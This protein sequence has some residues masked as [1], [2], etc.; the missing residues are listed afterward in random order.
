MI[1]VKRVS[2]PIILALL[3]VLLVWPDM[4]MAQM[5]EN[6]DLSTNKRQFRAVWIPTVLNI[7]WPSQPGLPEDQQKEEFTR[8]LDRSKEMG[9][10]AVIVQVRPTADAFYVSKMN[11]WSKYLMGKQ[12]VDPGYDPLSFMVEEAHKRNME[13]HAWFNPYRV[14]MD[15]DRSQLVPEHPARLYPDWVVEYG[16]RLYYN[17]GLPGPREHIVESIREVVRNYDIDAVHFDDYFYPYPSGGVDFP[18]QQTYEEYGKD[19][20][21]NKA[22]WRR[23]NVNQLV[24]QVSQ[25]IKEEKPYVKFGI[26]PFGIWRNKSTDPSGSDTDGLQSYDA[27]YADT[28]AWIQNEWIDYVTP[29]IYWSFGFPPA[30]Y[31]KLV[32]WW[33]N[34]VKDRNVHLYIGHAVYKIAANTPE[35]DN[36]DEIPNQINFNQ[37]FPEVKGSVFFSISDLLRNPLGIA[38]RLQNDVYQKPALIPAMPW[39]DDQAPPAPRIL[40]V[41]S[42]PDGNLIKWKDRPHSDARYFVVYRFLKSE[43]IQ[44]DD[45]SSIVAIVRNT[46]T[47]NKKQSYLDE[48]APGKEYKYVVTAVDRLHN[49]SKPSNAVA[50]K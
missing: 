6:Q 43:P 35:W 1:G 49:E 44:L 19:R 32:P 33:S 24:Q 13:F 48:K 12:G 47:K 39:I 34:E 42:K 22:D 10:N 18:D 30:A 15:T 36:P 50:E 26:S 38:D 45:P 28:R 27:I 40:F 4:S 21:A 20:F 8:L 2:V 7:S 41:R 3:T 25:A 11:P 16:G 14:S 5:K 9:M 46:D 29:Q 23:D 31:E 37:Q 17:P